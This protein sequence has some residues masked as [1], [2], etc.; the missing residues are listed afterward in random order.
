VYRIGLHGALEKLVEE[1]QAEFPGTIRLKFSAT[2]KLDQE[3]AVLL[4]DAIA[5]A[6]NDAIARPGSRKVT[7]SV[8]GTR[9]VVSARIQDDGR[10]TSKGPEALPRLLAQEAGFLF[11]KATRKGTIV[12]IRHGIPSPSRG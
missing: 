4:Y 6:L 9:R 7:L 3:L 8:T 12:L 2:A 11:Y 10:K 5:S 1:R